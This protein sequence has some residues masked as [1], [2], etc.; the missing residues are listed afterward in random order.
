MNTFTKTLFTLSLFSALGLSA[1]AEDISQAEL[2]AFTAQ[3]FRVD[4]NAQTDESKAGITKEF[5]QNAKLGDAL[6][7]GA[8]KDDIDLKIAKR[9]IAIEIWVQK[10]LASA[11]VDD[12]TVKALY[13]KYQPKTIPAYKLRNILVNSEEK[14]D[15][16]I[17]T[18]SKI[19]EPSKRLAKFKELVKSDS[20]DIQTNK[21][22]GNIDWIDLDKLNASV[23][24]PLKDKK[25][26]DLIKAQVPNIGWQVLLVE[27]TKPEHQATYEEAAPQ[28]TMVAKRE[29]L[30]QEIIK[31][32][33]SK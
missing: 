14:A 26:N 17:S 8:M 20:Q 27:D 24:A 15:S 22:E 30:N 6:L 5:T 21:N 28:L 11:K 9:Q 4:Y 18:L 23:Q 31:I 7:S 29:L 19:K 16:I 2:Q 10:F 25:N 12:A 32:L 13:D 3:K 33:E 1:Y